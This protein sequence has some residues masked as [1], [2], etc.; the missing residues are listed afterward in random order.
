MAKTPQEKVKELDRQ[1]ALDKQHNDEFYQSIPSKTI[2]DQAPS[3][4]TSQ[5][6]YDYDKIR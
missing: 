3:P 6:G 1:A 2:V 5:G 4:E